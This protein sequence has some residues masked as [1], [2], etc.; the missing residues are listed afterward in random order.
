MSY[1]D[2]GSSRRTPYDEHD[3]DATERA[4][5]DRSETTDYREPRTPGGFTAAP[6]RNGAGTTALILGILAL[7]FT[8]T[9]V[10]FLLG[11]LLAL[12][13]IAFAMVG[14][15]RVKRGVA[16]NRGAATTGMV[17]GVLSVILALVLGVIGALSFQQ[18][19]ECIDPGMSQSEIRQC[20]RDQMNF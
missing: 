4:E 9:V 2:R 17:L 19:R 7:L 12:I 13:A 10:F 11:L 20:V 3:A 6:P 1:D 16:T 14:R 18:V 8:V 5:R 15:S